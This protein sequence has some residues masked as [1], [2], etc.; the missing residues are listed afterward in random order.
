MVQ[1]GAWVSR[2]GVDIESLSEHK[3][4]VTIPIEIEI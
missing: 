4:G 3:S 1:L 2:I